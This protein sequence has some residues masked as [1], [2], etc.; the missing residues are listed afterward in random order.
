VLLA[1]KLAAGGCVV[2]ASAAALTLGVVTLPVYEI[3]KVGR[4]PY[5]L[6]GLDLLAATGL[7]AA[8]VPHF[9]NTDGGDHDTRFCFVGERRLAALE[10]ALPDG[11]FVLGVDEHT[12]AVFDLTA[13]TVEVL[14]RGGLTVRTAGRARRFD[15]GTTVPVAAIA[16]A[17]RDL[18]AAAGSRHASGP[19]MARPPDPV[20][21]E[22]GLAER[23]LELASRFGAAMERDDRPS[24]LA[25]LSELVDQIVANGASDPAPAGAARARLQGMLERWSRPAGP[26]PG[27]QGAALASLVGTILAGRERA[28]AQRHWDL[29]DALRDALVSAGIEVR[30]TPGGVEWSV[31]KATGRPSPVNEA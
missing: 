4:A 2:F 27:D 25:D 29:A 16:A 24:A 22:P 3:Y 5:W 23:A 28:R 11:A 6:P 19:A 12:A 31:E 30:D 1:D 8:V 21:A 9:D 26:D 17:A 13:A 7:R 10:A 20:A 15:R 14:G 18:V